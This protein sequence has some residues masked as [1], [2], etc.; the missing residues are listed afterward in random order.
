MAEYLLTAA[1]A[2]ELLEITDRAVRKNALAGKYGEV[3]YADST[4][5]GGK[6]GKVLRISLSALPASAQAV[7]AQKYH[8]HKEPEH[9]ETN[10]YDLAPAWQRDIANQ[11]YQI[12]KQYEAYITQPGRKT[13]LTDNF[14]SAWNDAYPED[15]ISRATLYNYQKKYREKGLAGLLTGYGKREEQRNIDE[16]ALACFH[17][18]FLRDSRPSVADAYFALCLEAKHNGW[19]IPSLRTMQR[20]AKEDIPAGVSTLLREGE[21]AYYDNI[22]TFTRR[23]PESIQAGQ[24][25]VGDHYRFDFFIRNGDSWVRPWLTAWLDM[26][27]HKLVGWHISLSPKVDTIVAAFAEAALDPTI[28][29]PRDIYIDNGRDYCSWRFAGRGARGKKLTDDDKQELKQEGKLV[30]SMM[31]RLK[32]TT[33]FAIVENARAKVIEREFKNIVEWFSKH[34]DMYCGRNPKERPE[35]IKEKLKNEKMYGMT[36]DRLQPLF[37]EWA[38]HVFNKRVSQKGKGREGECPDETFNRTR[39]P[40]RV[41]EQSVMQ[42]LFMKQTN[43]FKVGRNGITFNG[44]EYYF[45]DPMLYKGKFIYV[46][47]RPE[48]PESIWLYDMDDRLIGEATLLES[49]LAINETAERIKDESKRKKA[50]KQAIK[51]HPAYQNAKNAAQIGIERLTELQKIYGN[52]APD[53]E[54]TKVTEMV[55]VSSNDRE[56]AQIMKATGTDNASPMNVFEMMQGVKIEKRKGDL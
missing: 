27:S 54:R 10:E 42:L 37:S 3:R 29:L 20:I 31:D 30:E 49:T 5:R 33:H 28:G 4:S 40:V 32:I 53:P 13:E 44:R 41:A 15:T 8:L 55:F 26:R 56:S 48:H 35:A 22:Q 14:V 18:L 39:L 2:A 38:R 52:N 19:T 24:I 51:D 34:M 47:Y 12:L 17:G 45:A 46:R 11:R 21:K 36:L 9:V 43:P 1:E 23:D 50:E 16:A 25:Y 7:Y 6:S